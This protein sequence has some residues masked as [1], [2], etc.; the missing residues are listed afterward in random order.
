MPPFP[1]GPRLTQAK[2]SDE[3]AVIL[4]RCGAPCTGHTGAGACVRPGGR[5]VCV[6]RGQPCRHDPRRKKQT[7]YRGLRHRALQWL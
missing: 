2:E 6:A 5:R 3:T 4:L 1:S 7:L